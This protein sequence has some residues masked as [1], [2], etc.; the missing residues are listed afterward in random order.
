MAFEVGIH[1]AWL[2]LPLDTAAD[3]R[4]SAHLALTEVGRACGLVPL[5]AAVLTRQ[6]KTVAISGPSGAGKSTASLRLL[7]A[8]WSVVAEDSAWLDPLSLQVVGADQGLRVFESSVRQFAPQWLRKPVRRD[9]HG[10]WWF[11]LPSMGGQTLQRLYLLKDEGTGLIS[12]AAAV[13]ALWQASGVPLCAAAQ[14]MVSQSLARVA[15]HLPVEAVERNTLVAQ[16]SA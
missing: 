3:E 16:L 11:D 7:A 12:P 13:A 2:R 9:A 14:Q 5:H 15:Q 8:G 6:G 1:D 10:K 4:L